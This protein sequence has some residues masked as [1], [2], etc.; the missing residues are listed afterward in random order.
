MANSPLMAERLQTSI[1]RV[2]L[3][4]AIGLLA[5]AS[6][7]GAWH[8][9]P[10]GPPAWMGPRWAPAPVVAFLPGYPSPVHRLYHPPALPLSYFDGP[11][12]TTYCLSQRTGLYFVCA[13]SRPAPDPAEV[14]FALAPP[15]PPPPGDAAAPAPSGVLLFR[16]PADAEASLDGEPVGLSGGLGVAAVTP[17]QHRLGIR[18]GGRQVERIITVA[19]R[20]ILTITSSGISP[21]DP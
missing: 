7:A 20:A 21:A 5:G 11:S 1:L 12:G 9:G 19:S 2:G 14:P 16:L 13:Y 17:G 8:G 10:C 18:S 4:A 15:A 3:G 6:P